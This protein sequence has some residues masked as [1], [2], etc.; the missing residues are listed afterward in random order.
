MTP[1]DSASWCIATARVGSC[2]VSIT[3]TPSLVVTKLGL[4]PRRRVVV[5]TFGVTRS[6]I[7]TS[8]S[9][10]GWS[11][12]ALLGR[13]QP[14][15]DPQDLAGHERCSVRDEKDCGTG[16]VVRLADAA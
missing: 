4:Q 14:A 12:L 9:I 5:N 15:V 10:G 8:S 1:C 3:T 7:E 6:I 16:E 11:F 2:G 13:G